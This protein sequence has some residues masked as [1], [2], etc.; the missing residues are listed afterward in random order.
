MTEIP[1]Y[2]LR[3]CIKNNL[4]SRLKYLEA[5]VQDKVID[6][7]KAKIVRHGHEHTEF[8]FLCW[9]M[10]Y[11]Y[12]GLIKKNTVDEIVS[13]GVFHILGYDN[14]KKFFFEVYDRNR[15]LYNLYYSEC[16]PYSS[17]PEQNRPKFLKWLTVEFDKAFNHYYKIFTEK[18][19]NAAS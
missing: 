8:E 11:Y 2:S 14:S 13:D 17:D 1:E 10:N 18:N 3:N 7:I 12:D 5:G 19:K 15:H 4:A 16:R 6:A 9:Y